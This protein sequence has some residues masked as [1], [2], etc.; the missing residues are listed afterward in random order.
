MARVLEIAD[1][2]IDTVAKYHPLSATHMG[3]SGFDHLMPNYAPESAEAFN[4]DVLAARKEMESAI[5]TN[6]AERMCRDTFIDHVSISIEQHESREDLR[7]MNVLF[8]PVQSVRSIFDLMQRDSIE[9]WENI[10][11]RMEKI[12]ESLAGYRRT[13]DVGRSEGLVTSVRQVDGT[14]KQCEVWSGQGE[15][16][17]FF[18]SMVSAFWDSDVDDE[19]LAK[20]VKAAADSATV[21]YSAMGEYLRKEYMPS[22]TSVDGVGRDRYAL[23]AKAYLGAEID[24]EETYEWGWEQLAWVRS[25]MTDT[26][27]KIKNGATILEAIEILESD[28]Q[29]MITGEEKFRQWMQNLQDQTIDDMQGVHFDIAEPVRHIEALIAPPGGALAMYY[30]GPSEDF[31]RPGRT[32]YPTGGKTEFPIWREV[33]I[34]YHEGVP[35][36]HFQIASNVAM[37]EELSRFQRL[38]AGTSGHAEGWALYAERLMGELGYLEIPDYYMGMLDAQALRSVRVIVDIGMHL[39]LKIPNH[40]GFSAGEVWNAD[41]AL[42]FMR[43]NVHFPSD[44][45]ISEVDRYLGIPGQAISYKVGERVWLEARS[46]AKQTLGS[47]FD[48]K[49]WHNRALRL[50]PMGLAQMKRELE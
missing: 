29:K 28:P 1:G 30:T 17:P 41:L 25:E 45:L 24:L 20:R 44:F 46:S 37:T 14:A 27:K 13:L 9:A 3:I 15:S 10:A 49:T 43:K 5:P 6:E 34:A 7:D 21:A 38:I 36:H 50:G 22:A 31:S 42:E 39:G 19:A 12:N 32:W 40:S 16:A 8:S 11:S 23:S 18:D 48:L 47:G 33:S 4:S 26:A 35:G 2:F